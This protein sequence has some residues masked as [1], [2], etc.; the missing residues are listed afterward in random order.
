VNSVGERATCQQDFAGDAQVFF[1]AASVLHRVPA[2]I[3]NCGGQRACEHLVEALIHLLGG[4]EPQ[5]AA[6]VVR[7]IEGVAGGGRDVFLQGE[8]RK[9]SAMPVAS[10]LHEAVSVQ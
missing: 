1:S 8:A 7:L 2:D 10:L 5:D 6:G 4:V 9:A 3:T